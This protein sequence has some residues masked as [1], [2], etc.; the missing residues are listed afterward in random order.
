MQG[1]NLLDD[2]AILEVALEVLEARRQRLDDQIVAVR[3]LLRIRVD[4]HP[5]ES[6]ETHASA[7][8]HQTPAWRPGWAMGPESPEVEEVD[9]GTQESQNLIQ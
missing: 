6:D 9:T 7:P 1:K 2:P 5:M 3:A 8:E 4:S